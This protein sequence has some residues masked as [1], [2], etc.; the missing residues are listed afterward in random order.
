MYLEIHAFNCFC[1][2]QSA[3]HSCCTACK[4]ILA[5]VHKKSFW[6]VLQWLQKTNQ[7]RLILVCRRLMKLPR[8]RYWPQMSHR[9]AT[10]RP[11]H[12]MIQFH[13]QKQT[14]RKVTQRKLSTIGLCRC[15]HLQHRC[16]THLSQKNHSPELCHTWNPRCSSLKRCMSVCWVGWKQ[17]TGWTKTRIRQQ[18]KQRFNVLRNRLN[19]ALANCRHVSSTPRCHYCL[20][21]STRFT[22]ILCVQPFPAADVAAEKR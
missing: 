13:L 17:R 5:R 16:L 4:W 19:S 15:C 20:V 9:A 7:Q 6:S 11:Y 1:Q 12:S 2:C 8:A 10:L 14:Q 21:W 3:L 18:L 22:L